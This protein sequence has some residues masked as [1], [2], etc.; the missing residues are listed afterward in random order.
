MIKGYVI[1]TEVFWKDIHITFFKKL[2]IFYRQDNYLQSIIERIINDFFCKS[3]DRFLLV[4]KLK[5]IKNIT[6]FS[7]LLFFFIPTL[8]P[9]L[10]LDL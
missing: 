7:F 10:T 4:D 9:L 1:S 5:A 6:G 2:K 8:S 3:K